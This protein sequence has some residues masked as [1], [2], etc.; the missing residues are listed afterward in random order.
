V[1]RCAGMRPKRCLARKNQ[2]GLLYYRA[3]SKTLAR[4]ACGRHL[5]Q[6]T[7]DEREQI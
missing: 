3:P 1:E 4:P 6:R 2:R 7:P 5:S